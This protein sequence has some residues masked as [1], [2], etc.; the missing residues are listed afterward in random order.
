MYISCDANLMGFFFFLNREAW[1]TAFVTST[2]SFQ[3]HTQAHVHTHSLTVFEDLG[4]KSG[5]TA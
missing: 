2:H 5:S 3:K 1:D 4:L